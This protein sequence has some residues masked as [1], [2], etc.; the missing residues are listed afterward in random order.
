M[1]IEP[2]LRG[3]SLAR[4][5]NQELP[6]A[7]FFEATPSLRSRRLNAR[8]SRSGPKTPNLRDGSGPLASPSLGRKSPKQTTCL[9]LFFGRFLAAS[10]GN[11]HGTV[12]PLKTQLVYRVRVACR[13]KLELHRL[14]FAT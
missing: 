9:E 3:S 1:A 6:A 11:S 5:D 8:L 12:I 2:T 4:A 10:D 13:D 7:R 14:H